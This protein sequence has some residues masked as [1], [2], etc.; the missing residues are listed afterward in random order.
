MFFSLIDLRFIVNF[1]FFP[2][3]FNLKSINITDT[4]YD[5]HLVNAQP[6]VKLRLKSAWQIYSQVVYKSHH[7]TTV[8]FFLQWRLL[9]L[10]Q[11]PGRHLRSVSALYAPECPAH[12][13]R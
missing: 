4:R 5:F 2:P 7:F 10:G 9:G 3:L 6:L 11:R 1:E 8:F 13:R 12:T